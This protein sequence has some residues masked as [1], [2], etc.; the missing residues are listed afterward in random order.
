MEGRKPATSVIAA[1][2]G[3]TA[4]AESVAKFGISITVFGKVGVTVDTAS[5]VTSGAAPPTWRR[6][7]STLDSTTAAPPSDVAQISSRRRGSATI[8]DDNT[9]ST[10]TSLR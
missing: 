7:K 1:P 5:I 3:A 4:A 10:V 8:G 2:L 9:S 6:A